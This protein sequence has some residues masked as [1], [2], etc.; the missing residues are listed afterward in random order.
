[1]MFTFSEATF[2]SSC[3]W[4]TKDTTTNMATKTMATENRTTNQKTMATE[5]DAAAFLGSFDWAVHSRGST[6]PD[7]QGIRHLQIWE[8]PGE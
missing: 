3:T 6:T 1:M 2:T 4:A 8:N 5:R 7:W